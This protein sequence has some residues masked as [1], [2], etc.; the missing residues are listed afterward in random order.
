MFHG[1]LPDPH[2]N[3]LINYHLR[4]KQRPSHL[5]QE[6]VVYLKKHSVNI[7]FAMHKDKILDSSCIQVYPVLLRF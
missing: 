7:V 5:L 1:L 2:G 4:R 6:Q 3:M